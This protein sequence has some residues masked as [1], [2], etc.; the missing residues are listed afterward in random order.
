MPHQSY[1]LARPEDF[2][3]AHII[4][5]DAEHHHL[6]RVLRHGPG[7]H[8]WIT[9]GAGRMARGRIA[10]ITKQTT[11]VEVEELFHGYGEEAFRLTLAQA[12]PRLPRFEWLLEKGTEIGIAAFWP[13][14]AAR[15]TVR[16]KPEVPDRWDRLLRAA[17]KQCGRSKLPELHAPQPFAAVVDRAGA[18]DF[19]W[20]AHAPAPAPDCRWNFRQEPARGD[21]KS[22]LLLVGPEGGFADEEIELA[23]QRGFAFLELGTRRLRSETAGLTAAGL[24]LAQFRDVL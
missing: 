18:F 12:V 24:L 14:Q 2:S 11:V 6:S 10:E 23:R 3:R 22:G 9:D 20:I 8:V 17:L 15:S 21:G 13:M 5:R 4:L 1:F 7:D 16:L 19:C